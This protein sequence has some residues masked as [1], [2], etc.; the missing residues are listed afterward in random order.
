MLIIS[1]KNAAIDL[2][3]ISF[4]VHNRFYCF[5]TTESGEQHPF[6]NGTEIHCKIHSCSLF[7]DF[8]FEA[9]IM[10]KQKQDKSHTMS[11]YKLTAKAHTQS[12]NAIH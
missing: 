8:K 12:P 1:V 9:K 3:I 10:D 5:I 6:D 4:I 7:V 11:V 2:G